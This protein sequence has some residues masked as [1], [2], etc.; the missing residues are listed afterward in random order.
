MSGASKATFAT[1][2]PLAMAAIHGF[3]KDSL[4]GAD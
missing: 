4:F 3:D 1:F 2:L